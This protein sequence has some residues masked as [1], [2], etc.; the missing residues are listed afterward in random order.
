MSKN[1]AICQGWRECLHMQLLGFAIN[2]NPQEEI[3]NVGYVLVDER[4]PYAKVNFLIGI[5][6]RALSLDPDDG[7]RPKY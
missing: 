3:R 1:N 6:S 7:S 2:P 4:V 5:N